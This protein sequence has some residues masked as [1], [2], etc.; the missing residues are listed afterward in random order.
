MKPVIDERRDRVNRRRFLASTLALGAASLLGHSRTAAAEPPPEMTKVRIVHAPTMCLAPQYLV[1]DLLRA[2]GFVE[3]EYVPIQPPTGAY[4]QTWVDA[5]LSE[6]VADF[7]MA[8]APG[9]VSAIDGNASV[10]VLAGIHAGCFE[11]FGNGRVQSIRDLKGKTVAEYPY[12]DD[13][14]L[15]PP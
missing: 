14:L 15:S 6:G 13:R 5:M 4:K 9:H 11:L 1:E 3:V 10:V 12:G 7:A 2:E 8:A